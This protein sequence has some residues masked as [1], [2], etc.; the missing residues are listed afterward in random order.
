MSFV[1]LIKNFKN[2]FRFTGKVQRSIVQRISIYQ[3][4]LLITSEVNRIVTINEPV[5]IDVL[6]EVSTLFRFP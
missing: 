3:L 5:L 1:V 6:A 2:G 4:P